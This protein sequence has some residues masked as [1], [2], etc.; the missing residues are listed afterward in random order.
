MPL[1]VHSLR[2][3]RRYPEPSSVGVAVVDTRAGSEPTPGSVSA[4][5]DRCVVQTFGSHSRFCSS[6]PNSRSGCASP[7]DWCADSSVERLECQV[8]ASI[9]ARL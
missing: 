2:P 8:P 4:N 6:E 1:V 7:I 5:A 3:F 9:I